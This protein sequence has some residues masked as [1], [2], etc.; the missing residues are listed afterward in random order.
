M[1]LGLQNTSLLR[2][3][4]LNYTKKYIYFSILQGDIIILIFKIHKKC[5]TKKDFFG[6]N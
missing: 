3:I 1:L 6:N 2:I 5:L 4:S